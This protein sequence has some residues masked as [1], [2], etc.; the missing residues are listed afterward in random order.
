[1]VSLVLCYI[2][3]I[4]LIFLLLLD[5]DRVT[6]YPTIPKIEIQEY[7][8]NL[9]CLDHI[10]SNIEKYIHIAFAALEK[11]TM[12]LKSSLSGIGS[13]WQLNTTRP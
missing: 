5:F 1:M 7:H 12:P 9:E 3:H 4:W 2:S 13:I 10:L 6:G 8:C 11:G